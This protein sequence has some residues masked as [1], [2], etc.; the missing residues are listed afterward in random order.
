MKTADL[1]ALAA[2]A[3][4]TLLAT[5]CSLVTKQEFEQVQSQL[6]SANLSLEK[7][8]EN[9]MM[10][11]SQLETASLAIKD[12]QANPMPVEKNPTHFWELSFHF[13]NLDAV[14]QPGDNLR[15]AFK[16]EIKNIF[17]ARAKAGFEVTRSPENIVPGGKS[18]TYILRNRSVGFVTI[19]DKK[20]IDDAIE[21]V[22]GVSAIPVRFD[23]G[24]TKPLE[25]HNAQ[26]SY[27]SVNVVGTVDIESSQRCMVN[28]ILKPH[29]IAK[30]GAVAYVAVLDG[31]TW[32]LQ[33]TTKEPDSNKL[34]IKLNNLQGEFVGNRCKPTPRPEGEKAYIMAVLQNPTVAEYFELDIATETYKRK[35]VP[36]RFTTKAPACPPKDWHDARDAFKQTL[37]DQYRSECQEIPEKT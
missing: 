1:N 19:Q 16:Q 24:A 8:D 23:P 9:L 11:Q 35:V 36:G 32:K 15:S 28:L 22:A 18:F 21:T 17:D 30:A 26:Q 34:I 31:N 14:D 29:A 3:L 6:A 37:K 27:N 7:A 4:S 20:K 33:E 13:D 2:V 5:G 12:L 10:V 25:L